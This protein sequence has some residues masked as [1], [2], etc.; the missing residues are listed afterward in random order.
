MSKR[1]L[2]ALLRWPTWPIGESLGSER[3]RESSF[4]GPFSVSAK[5]TTET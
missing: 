1:M 3:G 4:R 5:L 2:S